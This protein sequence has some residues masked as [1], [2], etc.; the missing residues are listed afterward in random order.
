M[1]VGGER[2]V[3]NGDAFED[4]EAFIGGA[5]D[6]DDGIAAGAFGSETNRFTHL[7]K[8]TLDCAGRVG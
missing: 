8:V 7:D 3:V 2:A 5:C 1:T 4:G 6:V